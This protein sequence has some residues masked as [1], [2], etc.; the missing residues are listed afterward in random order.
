[1]KT[2]F[3]KGWEQAII[4][5]NNNNPYIT[6]FIGDF[7]ARN[8]NWWEGDIDNIPGLDL[9]ELSSHYGLTQ[10]INSP[11]HI[12][13][14]SAS[15]IDLI[16]T[17]EPN[18]ITKS[19]IH[20]SLFERCHHQIIYTK[21][22]FK[23]HFPP[24]YERL[25]WDYSMANENFIRRS[26]LNVDWKAA[27]NNLHV[28]D[29]VKFLTS[30]I[31]NVFNNF[32][33]SKT[34]IFKDKDPPWMNNKIRQ[35]CLNKA[36]IYK[37]YVKRGRTNADKENLRNITNFSANIILDAKTRYLSCLGNKLNNPQLGAKAYWSILNKFLH[38]KKIPLIP[39]LL[40]NNSLVTNALKKTSLFND[41][42]C[43]TMYSYSKF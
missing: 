7:N 10:L 26:L 41:F 21:I 11:T 30:C 25:L 37:T 23:I 32:V 5:I 17:S 2:E 4:N 31:L 33:P 14:N 16:F 6:I 22:N 28:N 24:P 9:D 19:G 15:C 39:P 43:A 42:F 40:V 18:L 12:L 13:P 1:M 27:L 36:K 20:A 34:I 8:R 29:Q 35:L 38:K 3:K